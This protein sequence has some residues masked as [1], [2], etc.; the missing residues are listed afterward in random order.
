M[1]KFAICHVPK[2]YLSPFVC[3][4]SKKIS[5]ITNLLW[6]PK[7][8]RKPDDKISMSDGFIIILALPC[9]RNLSVICVR[10]VSKF[11]HTEV[12]DH[13]SCQSVD[14]HICDEGPILVSESVTKY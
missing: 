9:D 5:W 14:P 11:S 1:V 6:V 12:V 4:C 7:N 13:P 10:K 3:L 8:V 2:L